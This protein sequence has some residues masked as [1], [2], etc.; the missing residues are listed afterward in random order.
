MYWLVII[1]LMAIAWQLS[2]P[3]L[4]QWLSARL[5][6]ARR[7]RWSGSLIPSIPGLK[8]Y[9]NPRD[10]RQLRASLKISPKLI[11]SLERIVARCALQTPGVSPAIELRL[12]VT[13]QLVGE[14]LYRGPSG[15]RASDVRYICEHMGLVHPLPNMALVP[16][17]PIAPEHAL[18][19]SLEAPLLDAL[20]KVR[21][22]GLL[23]LSVGLAQVKLSSGEDCLLLLTQPQP[24]E[25]QPFPRHIMGQL[26]VQLTGRCPLKGQLT[27]WLSDGVS[28]VKRI[29]IERATHALRG[30]FSVS[31]P[32]M[33]RGVHRAELTLTPNR[34]ETEAEGSDRSSSPI[35][36]MS[37][38]LFNNTKPPREHSLIAPSPLSRFT[39]FN[40]WRVIS[41]LQHARRPLGLRP[42]KLSRALSTAA[43]EL[44]EQHDV[45]PTTPLWELPSARSLNAPSDRLEHRDDPPLKIGVVTLM[46]E[47]WGCDLEDIVEQWLDTPHQRALLTDL[48]A[49]HLGL[50]IRV[51]E[52]GKPYVLL[53]LSARAARLRL[54]RD[55]RE[56][57]KQVQGYRR[58]SG[59]GRLPQDEQLEGIAQEVA[60]GLSTG[61]CRPYEVL[62]HAQHLSVERLG[63]ELPLVAEAWPLRQVEQLS[64]SDAWVDQ[65]LGVGVGLAQLSVDAPIWVV[66]ILRVRAR[67]AIGDLSRIQ[68]QLEASRI[69]E[70]KRKAEHAKAVVQK[71]LGGGR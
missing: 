55:R 54:G 40:Q 42:L 3:E 22:E 61:Q 21:V 16:I 36:L 33:G 6:N 32:N 53:L 58:Q 1:G 65:P 67:T 70:E 26:G 50:C 51:D 43:T 48:S 15:A 44:A 45:Y 10:E 5:L 18:V 4:S 57:Y 28:P 31:L 60:D 38:S 7:P 64:M 14:L 69:A 56:V 17:D 59:V 13:A 19:S 46:C 34:R 24:C 47:A 41:L 66:V 52:R 20:E 2:Q 11:S 25:L 37:A 49:T 9:Q 71:R 30:D 29:P 63:E 39:L 12:C 8:L 62:Q 27:L 35:S 23:R 68:T